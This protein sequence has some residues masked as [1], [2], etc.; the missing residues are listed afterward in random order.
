NHI[1]IRAALPIAKAMVGRHTII[2]HSLKCQGAARRFAAQIAE[3]SKQ[4]AFPT[5]IPE[6]M[7]NVVEGIAGSDPTK[8]TLIFM[9][10]VNDPSSLRSSITPFMEH[11]ARM[12]FT[13]LP[14]PA[15]GDD[16]FELTLSRIMLGD[17]VSLFIA[18]KRGID[19]TPIRHI[20]AL[21]QSLSGAT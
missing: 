11:F 17:F 14:F 6:A 20:I 18:A 15:A 19:P 9:S 12:G 10:D 4:L 2:F 1:V 5:M 8:W 7:H 13:C 21:K 3:N 16:Q